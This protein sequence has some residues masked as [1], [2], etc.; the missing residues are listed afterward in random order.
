MMVYIMCSLNNCSVA[1]RNLSLLHMYYACTMYVLR[2]RHNLSTEKLLQLFYDILTS[3][4]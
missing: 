4:E 1:K 2:I 3:S